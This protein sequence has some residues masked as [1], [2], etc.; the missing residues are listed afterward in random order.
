M[1][2]ITM[3]QYSFEHHRIAIAALLFSL[4][5]L[6]YPLAAEQST[7]EELIVTA[8]R[9]DQ[10]LRLLT[11]NAMGID[12]E[13]LRLIAHTHINEALFEIP[14]AWI[15]R[16]NGQEHLT[17]I[18]SP[19]LTGAG[20][21]G[22]FLMA[23]DGIPLRAT[24]FCNVNELFESNSEQAERIEV[25][26]GPGPAVFGSNAM[27]GIVNVITPTL[28]S[29]SH[30]SLGLEAGPHDYFRTRFSTGNRQWRLDALGTSDGGYK[31]GAG[32][33]QQKVSFKHEADSENMTVTSVFSYNNLNQET[34]GFISGF[35]AYKDGSLRQDNPNPEAFRDV[36][37]ARF[38]SRFDLML[39][40]SRLTVTPYLRMTDMRFLQHFLP[41]Q[42]LEENGHRSVGVQSAWYVSPGDSDL[43]TG[44][45]IELTRGFLQEFQSDPTPGSAFLQATIPPGWHYDYEVDAQVIAAF[46]QLS[47]PL[48]LH[49]RLVAGLRIE[50][51]HYDYDNQ[52]LDGRTRDDGTPCGF[53]GCR[54]SRPADRSDS[55]THLSPKLGL[56]HQFSVDHQV[57]AQ[58]ARG[59]RAPQTTE[60]YRLQNTQQVSNIEEEEIDSIEVGFRGGNARLG[61]DV[62]I[63]SMRKDN[64]IFRD[65]TRTNVDNGKTSHRGVDIRLDY[66]FSERFTLSLSAAF[67]RHRYE[68]NPLLSATPI[69]G[70]SI[71]TAPEEIVSA[72]LKWRLGHS[73]LL[74]LEWL[75][76]GEYYV[77]PQNLNTYEGHNLLNLRY[78]RQLNDYWSMSARLMNLTDEEYA[79]RADFG[80]GSH[81]YFVGE[82]ASLYLSISRDF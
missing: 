32:F 55:F 18:R 35:E 56:T 5:V 23:Q 40:D 75:H 61:Y 68:N 50:N 64:F 33:D 72:R 34:A 36:R 43:I 67:S 74:S 38:H 82:P 77:D 30:H 47:T 8:T 20:G 51:V 26:K 21:C 59:F 80:F 4:V 15:S 37:S 28:E 65:T 3:K 17:A 13:T 48:G 46:A 14:G 70:N 42:A 2:L 62:S 24:G 52:M 11:H 27:H 16:G 1:I 9:N 45:D 78:K 54:F 60:L 25:I 39:N 63:Y 22:A 7:M 57:Y 44:I 19:V 29:Q 71:D 69:E 12:D 58:L 73:A 41:G 81:R 31:Q 66:E 79:E 6:S 10:E 49:T 76:M 53:G